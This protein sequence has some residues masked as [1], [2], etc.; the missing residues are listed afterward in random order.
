M[1][2]KPGTQ[3]FE[4]MIDFMR[5]DLESNMGYTKIEMAARKMFKEQGRDFDLEFAKWKE[6]R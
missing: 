5:K 3:E 6:K 1:M 2:P 4:K